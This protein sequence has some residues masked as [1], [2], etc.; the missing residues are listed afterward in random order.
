[1]F[2]NFDIYDRLNPDSPFHR[3]PEC[4]EYPS[5]PYSEVPFQGSII[6]PEITVK[7]F[8]V[9]LTK[10]TIYTHKAQNLTS[11]YRAI[12]AVM[13]P[14]STK[15]HWLRVSYKI[16]ID[17]LWTGQI[18]YFSTFVSE[19]AYLTVQFFHDI[20]CNEF[21]DYGDLLADDMPLI[22]IQIIVREFID[23]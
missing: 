4:T 14:N 7:Y 12:R 10:H 11:L 17:N 9:T 13:P 16:M 5:S 15:S 19:N 21:E 20:V 23:I 22:D 8:P 18:G 3:M 2:T 1:M 6:S